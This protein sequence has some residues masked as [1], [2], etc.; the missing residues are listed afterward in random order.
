MSDPMRCDD[1]N[2]NVTGERVLCGG[3]A[4]AAT[5]ALRAALDDEKR[6]HE[7]ALAERDLHWREVESLRERLDKEEEERGRQYALRVQ[8]EEQA[9]VAEAAA[10]SVVAEAHS[11]LRLCAV[12]EQVP[13]FKTPLA[14][15]AV[16]IMY[17]S[18]RRDEALTEAERL[19]TLVQDWYEGRARIGASMTFVDKKFYDSAR[20]QRTGWPGD[21]ADG[22]G[23][24][25]EE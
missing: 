8:A 11:T 4:D 17:L 24:P 10:R 21:D 16:R 5:E 9:K 2:S 25:P 13:P 22:D 3:C 20:L 15:L 23:G 6:A 19:M 12:P 14:P 1:C 18:E 7:V